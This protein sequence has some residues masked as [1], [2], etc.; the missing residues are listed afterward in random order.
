MTWNYQWTYQTAYDSRVV[1]T[2]VPKEFRDTNLRVEWYKISSNVHSGNLQRVQSLVVGPRK[3]GTYY[4]ETLP[5]RPNELR[6]LVLTPTKS[7]VTPAP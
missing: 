4:S 2:N 7:P 6:L 3:N 1:I 5:L